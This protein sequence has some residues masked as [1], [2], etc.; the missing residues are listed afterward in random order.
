MRRR[1]PKSR[2]WPLRA[3][4]PSPSRR[5][6]KPDMSQTQT[7]PAP[8]KPGPASRGLDIPK[9]LLEGRAFIAL[10]VI[11]LIFSFLSPNYFTVNNLLTMS[12]HVA[13]YAILAIGMLMVILN[14]GIA[15]SVGS[16]VWLSGV[17]AGFLMQGVKLPGMEVTLYPA[18]WVCAV[19]ALAV[20]ALVGWV[21]GILVSKFGVAPFVATLG[22]L[23][24]VRGIA[25]L[26]T[27]G[28]TYPNLR[29]EAALGNTGFYAL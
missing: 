1:P 4:L 10:I 22:T 11:I 29:G 16:T 6:R 14:G 28:L 3:K 25:L 12:A 15:L 27:N 5:E 23:Y 7:A 19:C 2:L 8:A 18:V 20:G 17:I 26:I 13:V 21:N 24:V 9:L